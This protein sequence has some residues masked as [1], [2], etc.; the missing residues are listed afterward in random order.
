MPP[1]GLGHSVGQPV[2]EQQTVGQ[3]GETVVE[4]H[5]LDLIVLALAVDGFGDVMRDVAQQV[6]VGLRV[7]A[8]LPI[9]L[10]HQRAERRFARSKG[11]ADPAH[12]GRAVH[13]DS[14]GPHRVELGAVD[15]LGFALFEQSTAERGPDGNARRS[16]HI[17]LVA[18]VGE[19]EVL[20]GRI[21]EGDDEIARVDQLPHR[22]VNG[23]QEIRQTQRAGRGIGDPIDRGLRPLGPAS[24][25]DV[26]DDALHGGLVAQSHATTEDLDEDA[27]AIRPPQDVFAGGRD[28]PATHVVQGLG[29]AWE[30]LDGQEVEDVAADQ[31]VRGGE[32]EDAGDGLVR[33]D[34]RA[35]DVHGH[36]VGQ[37][38]DQRPIAVLAGA[39]GE[40]GLGFVRHVLGD[41]E[42]GGLAAEHA[43]RRLDAGPKA[44][45]ISAPGQVHEGRLNFARLGAARAPS[46]QLSHLRIH[47]GLRGFE[48]DR[49]FERFAER[50]QKPGIRIDDAA[51]LQDHKA[52]GRG[53]EDL[54]EVRLPKFDLGPREGRR[55]YPPI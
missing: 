6:P 2:L 48:T 44:P 13:R 24:L 50:P 47:D 34:D 45:A 27:G 54:G 41:G 28:F 33:E 20:P 52:Q 10:N 25:R 49:F 39:Q 31:I 55:H 21:D 9:A 14:A 5:V 7:S 23:L 19:G 51:L 35:A 53:V 29:R 11:H 16:F 4:G 37:A 46:G 40:R 38:V 15:Q 12:R 26:A 18:I 36:A 17:H 1:L 30:F 32:A 22:R 8:L 42:G 3:A 43:G